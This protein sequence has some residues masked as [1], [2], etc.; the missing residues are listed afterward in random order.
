MWDMMADLKYDAVTPGDLEMVDGL[1]SLK[2]VTPP[3]P[4]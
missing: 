3:T 2:E 4:R 1:A